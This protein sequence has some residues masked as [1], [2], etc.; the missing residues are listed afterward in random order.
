MP[1]K[2]SNNIP[3][4][5]KLPVFTKL[6]GSPGMDATEKA[7]V[8]EACGWALAPSHPF[9]QQHCPCAVL[10]LPVRRLCNA[11]SVFCS[12]ALAPVQTSFHWCIQPLSQVPLLAMWEWCW[13]LTLDCVSS[14]ACIQLVQATQLW[15][16]CGHY[17]A[18]LLPQPCTSRGWNLLMAPLP[19]K[20]PQQ[21]VGRSWAWSQA[22][23][24]A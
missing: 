16:G 9:L 3:I 23:L 5:C 24:C 10:L 21:A 7:T 19:Q 4:L 17:G 15:L 2:K 13:S 6:W 11:S 18:E 14:P 20:W 1:V 8:A 12:A 22:W